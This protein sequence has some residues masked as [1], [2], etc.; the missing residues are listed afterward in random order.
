MTSRQAAAAAHGQLGRLL[1]VLNSAFLAPLAPEPA[2]EREDAPAS[3]S[4]PVFLDMLA[5]FAPSVFRFRQGGADLVRESC[6]LPGLARMARVSGSDCNHLR[7]RIRMYL[8]D[9]GSLTEKPFALWAEATGKHKLTIYEIS[10]GARSASAN[11]TSSG[12]SWRKSRH[13]CS[14]EHS[15]SLGAARDT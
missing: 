9:A 2:R 6:K 8:H 12:K 7:D 1:G 3:V 11:L 13:F 5:V 15:R 10:E 4:A 14:R